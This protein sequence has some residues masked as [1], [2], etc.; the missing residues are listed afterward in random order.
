MTAQNI[1]LNILLVEDDQDDIMFFKEAAG[2]LEKINEV[3]V[4]RN[5]EQLFKETQFKKVFDLIFL[6]INL[7]LMDGKQCLKFIK[8]SERYKDVPIIMFTG[9]SAD[10]DIDEAYENGAH[11]HVVKPIAHSNY[12]ESLRIIFGHNWKEAQPRPSKEDFV[13]NLAFT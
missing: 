7:P 1:G 3:T 10:S 4:A 2:K 11:Y 9:S 13:V 12:I 8:S 6:D 5:C